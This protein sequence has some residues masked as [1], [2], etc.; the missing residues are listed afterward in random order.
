GRFD[1]LRDDLSESEVSVFRPP[2]EPTS[3]FAVGNLVVAFVGIGYST[4]APRPFVIPDQRV[5]FFPR[6]P[7][8][9]VPVFRIKSLDDPALDEFI[10]DLREI[11]RLAARPNPSAEN[12]RS[13]NAGNSNDGRQE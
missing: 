3:G 2:H 6:T 5:Q 8:Y 7:K 1:P 9:R 13:S 12:G 11:R 4:Q 10:D